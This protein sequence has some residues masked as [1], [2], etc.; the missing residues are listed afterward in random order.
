MVQMGQAATSRAPVVGVEDVGYC[1]W[2]GE[3]VE[4][5]RWM[6]LGLAVDPDGLS[7]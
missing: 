1:P 3:E 6:G 5:H 7:R 2:N 4:R